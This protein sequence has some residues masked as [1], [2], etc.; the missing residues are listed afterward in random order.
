V[1]GDQ[2]QDHRLVRFEV[3]HRLFFIA[4]HEARI[5]GDVR[6]KDSREASLVN[7]ESLRRLG[8]GVF[9]ATLGLRAWKNAGGA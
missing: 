3:A 5:T 1:L 4:P 8:H 7:V 9:Q 2:R 6:G